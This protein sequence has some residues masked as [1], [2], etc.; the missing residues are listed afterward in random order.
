MFFT[1]EKNDTSNPNREQLVHDSDWAYHCCFFTSEKND[2]SNQKSQRCVSFGQK[3]RPLIGACSLQRP[4]FA[5]IRREKFFWKSFSRVFT[6][7]RRKASR[8]WEWNSFVYFS[9]MKRIV[10]SWLNNS[11]I[12]GKTK[13]DVRLS[14]AFYLSYF[15]FF[16]SLLI[17]KSA[18]L[19]KFIHF[20]LCI[21]N[22]KL[23]YL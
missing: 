5:D 19:L 10:D 21:Q 18:I 12:Q 20:Q 2:T 7:E 11:E 22:K 17:F 8:K 4:R 14:C 15:V 23:T 16:L 13:R 6:R 3:F 1:R 9:V